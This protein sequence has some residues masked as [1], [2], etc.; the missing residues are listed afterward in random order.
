MWSYCV[1]IQAVPLAPA[2]NGAFCE[3]EFMIRWKSKINELCIGIHFTKF[4]NNSECKATIVYSGACWMFTWHIIRWVCKML[5]HI[6][7]TERRV[8]QEWKK[9]RKVDG[10]TEAP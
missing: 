4:Q 8:G 5:K 1:E 10:E 6:N 7:A 3:S 9:G 2:S